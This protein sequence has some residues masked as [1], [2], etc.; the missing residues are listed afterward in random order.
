M[1]RNPSIA[2]YSEHE[3]E[4]ARR[5]TAKYNADR[6]KIEH[7][8]LELV[9]DPKE[10]EAIYNYMNTPGKD[11]EELN[12]IGDILMHNGNIEKMG[13]MYERLEALEEEHAGAMTDLWEKALER[14]KREYYG[15]IEPL[16][17]QIIE[18]VK[19]DCTNEDKRED[20]KEDKERRKNKPHA[21]K[22]YICSVFQEYLQ[23]LQYNDIEKFAELMRFIVDL[24][25]GNGERHELA[26]RPKSQ[27]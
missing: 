15:D 23:F 1:F 11:F 17:N 7:E 12:K 24:T 20:R 2:V 27:S 6:A 22:S 8:I 4:E 19:H 13:V 26:R 10:A 14:F 5:L 9:A 25:L 21:Q 16:K 3:R 18:F